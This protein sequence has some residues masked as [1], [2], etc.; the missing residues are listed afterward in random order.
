MCRDWADLLDVWVL[1][2]HSDGIIGQP[3]FTW[4][5]DRFWPLKWHFGS[6]LLKFI[7]HWE[8][9]G[10]RCFILWIQLHSSLA[11]CTDRASMEYLCFGIHCLIYSLSWIIYRGLI[12]SSVFLMCLAFRPPSI[13]A[14]SFSL[15]SMPT[16][17]LLFPHLSICCCPRFYHSCSVWAES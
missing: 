4:R 1:L 12:A 9:L 2:N 11:Y 3:R 14:A 7:G 10:A 6:R 17:P 8:G 16:L 5:V 15:A 13:I